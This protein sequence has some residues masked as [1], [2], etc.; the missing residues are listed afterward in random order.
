MDGNSSRIP[1]DGQTVL[2][3]VR[4]LIA[5]TPVTLRHRR[6]WLWFCLTLG[7]ATILAVLTWAEITEKPFYIP[8]DARQHVFWM[9]RFVNP[10]LFP[11]DWIADYFQ[12]VAPLGYVWVYRLAAILGISPLVFNGLLPSILILLTAIATFLTCLELC[13]LPA[14]GFAASVLLAQSI[15]YTTSVASGTPKAFVFLGMML[16]WHGWLRRSWGLTSFSVLFQGLFYPPTVLI[17]TGVLVLGLLDRQPGGKWRITRDRQLWKLTLAG[18]AIACGIIL[19]YGLSS[20]EFGPTITAAE[21]LDMP[22][23]HRGG[24]GQFFRP[25]VVD[26]LLYGRS[27]LQVYNAFTPITNLFALVLPI[28]FCFPK[29]FP[30]VTSACARLGLL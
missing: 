18:L 1:I 24:R 6:V 15:E 25:S 16:L 23:F 10:G 28:L 7:Y 13:A 27:G 17:S 12:S 4:Q 19:Q 29:R 14:V 21:A 11:H 2:Q 22:E 5:P 9:Q 8:D 26:Y 20:S 3:T 30:L